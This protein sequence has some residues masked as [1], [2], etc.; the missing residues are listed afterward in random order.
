MPGG[1]RRLNVLVTRARER[2]HLVTSIPRD[3]Y[4]ALPPVPQG[5]TPGGGWLLFSYLQFAEQLQT[6]YATIENTIGAAEEGHPEAEALV[7]P[8]HEVV[9]NQTRVPSPLATSL[10]LHLKDAAGIGSFVHWGN[11]GF[12]IDVAMRHPVSLADVTLGIMC[13]WTRFPNAQNPIEWDMFRTAI[14]ESQG[15]TIRRVW[16]PQ[17]FRDLRGLRE[18][19]VARAAEEARKVK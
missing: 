14:L 9:I 8:S 5:Q 12:C 11:D 2:V 17:L 16:S 19:L 13:D 7:A 18:D 3:T 4:L 15:W 10:A 1:G 6:E